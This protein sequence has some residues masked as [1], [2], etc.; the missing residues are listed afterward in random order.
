MELSVIMKS[1]EVHQ[2]QMPNPMPGK[3]GLHEDHRL[4]TEGA[5][6]VEGPGR[7]MDIG[8]SRIQQSILAAREANSYSNRS[9]VSSWREVIILMSST[10]VRPHLDTVFSLGPSQ[11]KR[12]VVNWCEFCGGPKSG[13]STCP[14]ERVCECR[15]CLA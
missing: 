6:L 8:L 1:I 5:A 10:P 14:E 13:W 3:E 12:T 4:V 2:R 11:T 9:A 15:V 7:L